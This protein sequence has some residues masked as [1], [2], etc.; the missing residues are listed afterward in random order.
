M[1]RDLQLH[2]S[3]WV[4]QAVAIHSTF[5]Q[6]SLLQ[7]HWHYHIRVLQPV[8]QPVSQVNNQPDK[9]F[10]AVLLSALHCPAKVSSSPTLV[11]Y[12]VADSDLP[13]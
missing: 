10:P 5:C 1:H 4:L 6:M 2:R 12:S 3:L 11:M 8:R 13:G 7:D 9:Q